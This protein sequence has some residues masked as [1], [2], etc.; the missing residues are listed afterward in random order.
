MNS[1]AG[2]FVVTLSNLSGE[3]QNGFRELVNKNQFF[4]IQIWHIA[5][6]NKVRAL[7]FGLCVKYNKSKLHSCFVVSSRGTLRSFQGNHELWMPGNRS[8]R[9]W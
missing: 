4:I 8:Y 6:S 3:L 2:F 9:E 5:L 1:Q 7:L